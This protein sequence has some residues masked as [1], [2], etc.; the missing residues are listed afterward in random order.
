[1]SQPSQSFDGRDLYPT[2][3]AKAA[4]LLWWITLNHPY[5]DGNKRVALTTA[6]F[7]LV[8]NHRVVV[9]TI[10]EQVELCLW[11]AGMEPGISF[12]GLCNWIDEHTYTFPEFV[13]IRHDLEKWEALLDR[14]SEEEMLAL[15]RF[16]I[17]MI[18][19][20]LPSRN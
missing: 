11:V 20:T 8:A 18:D 2:L 13:N 19:L 16:V 12:N 3:S 14:Y 10:E 4:A 1:M 7:F 6:A 9:A 17:A 5:I 15:A